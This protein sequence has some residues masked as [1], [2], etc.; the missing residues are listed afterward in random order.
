MTPYWSRMLRSA[1]GTMLKF[2][3]IGVIR[4]PVEPAVNVMMAAIAGSTPNG[5]TMSGTST[6]VVMTGKAANELPITSVKRV[7]PRQFAATS[8]KRLSPGMT[9]LMPAAMSSPTLL[10]VKM[11]PSDARSCGRMMTEPMESL[12]LRPSSNASRG[13]PF[14][15]ASPARSAA[16]PP[17]PRPTSAPLL[18][19]PPARRKASA[20]PKARSGMSST[21]RN[22]LFPSAGSFGAACPD[23]VVSPW[24]GLCPTR[25]APSRPTI[26]S[27]SRPQPVRHHAPQDEDG[28][29][30]EPEEGA[31]PPVGVVAVAEVQRREDPEDEPRQH[32]DRVEAEQRGRDV[33]QRRHGHSPP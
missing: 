25:P 9:P 6:P 22:I 19:S 13:P 20:K 23:F 24:C 32:V 5:L 28:P 7:I 16:A 14:V 11:T 18:V 2:A 3:A 4:V 26:K 12:S 8:R 30:D 21:G 27:T 1:A 10:A 31:P 15:S 33:S 29:E 17:K